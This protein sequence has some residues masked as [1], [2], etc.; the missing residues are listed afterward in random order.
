MYPNPA[1]N[2]LNIDLPNGA[3]S[4]KVEFYDYVGKSALRGEISPNN[5]NIN[6]SDLSSDMYILKVITDNKIDSKK[7][8]KQ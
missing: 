3:V 5:N 2:N 4:A 8:I 1:S 6:V 7:F